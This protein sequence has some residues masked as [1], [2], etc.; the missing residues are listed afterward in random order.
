MDLHPFVVHFPIALLTL[1]AVCDLVGVLADRE[2]LRWTGFLLL[3]VGTIGALIA[4]LTGDAAE[5]VAGQIPGIHDALEQHEDFA[6]LTIW[7]AVFLVL[8]RAHFV[9]KRRFLGVARAVYLVLALCLAALVLYSGYTG[10]KMVHDF[11]AGTVRAEANP[12][13]RIQESD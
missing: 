2:Q 8:G 9:V 11:E 12:E 1:S 13:A 5:H 4:A 3:V 10:G 7:T 6:T